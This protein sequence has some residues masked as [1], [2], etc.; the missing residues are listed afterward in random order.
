MCKLRKILALNPLVNWIVTTK[1]L[2]ANA[3]ESIAL[4]NTRAVIVSDLSF[5]SALLTYS[6]SSI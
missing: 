6:K 5:V 1:D 4:L 3:T 2:Q